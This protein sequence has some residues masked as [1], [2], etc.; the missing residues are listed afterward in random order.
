MKI[1]V[2][3]RETGAGFDLGFEGDSRFDIDF[4]ERLPGHSAP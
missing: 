3:F 1:Q 2:E 4:E